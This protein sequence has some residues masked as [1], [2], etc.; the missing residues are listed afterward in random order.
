MKNLTLVDN[1]WLERINPNITP[2]ERVVL[3]DKT[4]PPS[5]AKRALMESI[6]SRSSKPADPTDAA[7]AQSIYDQHKLADSTLIAVDVTLPNG[8]GIINC[9][10]N[11]EHKQIR[12]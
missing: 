5:E 3:E 12:F 4:M 11:G 7:T 10:L 8:H 1:V 2:E 9:R 6:K